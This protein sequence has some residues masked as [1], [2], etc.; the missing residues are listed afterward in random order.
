M[1]K[2]RDH[3][4]DQSD[5]RKHPHACGEDTGT[6]RTST[7][8]VETP[9]RVWGRLGLAQR[10]QRAFGNT[11][12]RVGKTFSD[13]GLG[14]DG[15]KHPHACGE[16]ASLKPVQTNAMET[17]P[18]VWGRPSCNVAGVADK[19]NTPTRVGKTGL[20]QREMPNQQKHPHACG[21]DHRAT[22][23]GYGVDR[24]TP[25]RVGKTA[26]LTHRNLRCAE[27]P[28]RVWGRHQHIVKEPYRKHN[29]FGLL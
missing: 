12:T 9:P 14:V 29:S 11:P 24:N 4:H 19:R 1:G 21:E 10:R 5:R 26:F 15:G 23:L 17:P 7:L 18:R 3:D 20:L 2:T 28:P 16:D 8:D 25:T 22:L 6:R 27:T 13:I